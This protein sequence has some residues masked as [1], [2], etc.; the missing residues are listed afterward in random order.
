MGTTDW[1]IF[2]YIKTIKNDL[3]R[4]QYEGAMAQAGMNSF[5][6]AQP[7]LSSVLNTYYYSKKAPELY[8]NMVNNTEN[9]YS[10]T[11]E[12]RKGLY[13]IEHIWQKGSEPAPNDIPTNLPVDITK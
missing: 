6:I 10:T 1:K 11:A 5:G 7:F 8:V 2:E 3:P 4:T 12:I 13:K 9:A